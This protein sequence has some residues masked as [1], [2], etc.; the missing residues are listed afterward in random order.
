MVNNNMNN[1]IPHHEGY[2]NRPSEFLHQNISTSYLDERLGLKRLCMVVFVLGSP[3]MSL[4]LSL[5][6]FRSFSVLSI[7][8]HM[9]GVHKTIYIYIYKC[10][11]LYVG[12][13]IVYIY[14]YGIYSI[15]MGRIVYVIYIYIYMY[16]QG[17]VRAHTAGG[18]CKHYLG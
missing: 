9:S 15:Y 11:V 16:I 7:Y 2:N 10:C 14:I 4:S 1:P 3:G 6:L 18:S 12:G 8:I 5:A 17:S 13:F